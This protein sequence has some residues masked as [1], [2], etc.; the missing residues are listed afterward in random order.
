MSKKRNPLKKKF[1]VIFSRTTRESSSIEIEAVSQAAAEK[2][3]EKFLED[4]DSEFH[5]ED[6]DFGE[7][8]ISE[9]SPFPHE[10]QIGPGTA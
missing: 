7:W 6:C 1:L 9:I 4:P 5:E 10:T 2:A 3:A 8:E